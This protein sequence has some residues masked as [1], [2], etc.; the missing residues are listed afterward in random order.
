MLMAGGSLS[1][2]SDNPHFGTLMPL[3]AVHPIFSVPL[4]RIGRNGA[5]T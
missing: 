1:A 3:G 4:S 5:A 2:G